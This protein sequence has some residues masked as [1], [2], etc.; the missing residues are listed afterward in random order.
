MHGQVNVVRSTPLCAI[1][2]RAAPN[3]A[4]IAY[5]KRLCQWPGGADLMNT[6]VCMARLTYIGEPITL[7]HLRHCLRL[8]VGRSLAN[9]IE[10]DLAMSAPSP[11]V[12]PGFSQAPSQPPSPT[13]GT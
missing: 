8:C 11:G 6:L 2:T 3:A 10:N 1:G 9:V 5:L 4:A 7:L 13:A 12:N